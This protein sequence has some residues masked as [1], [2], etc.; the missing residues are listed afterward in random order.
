MGLREL[1]IGDREEGGV[2]CGWRDGSGRLVLVL[3]GVP[4]QLLVAGKLRLL[5][6]TV[7]VPFVKLFA[8][9][10]SAKL[11]SSPSPSAS[12]SS[13]LESKSVSPSESTS[14]S[15]PGSAVTTGGSE[16]SSSSA[17]SSSSPWLESWL[18]W[19]GSVSQARV[20]A[21]VPGSSSAV[22]A[23]LGLRWALAEM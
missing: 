22:E 1:V 13:S 16:P 17:A 9:V 7:L 3:R 23:V 8:F 20:P 19:R 5:V 10:P 15:S 2:E 14:S 21:L 4:E 12:A 6:G 11:S 18:E